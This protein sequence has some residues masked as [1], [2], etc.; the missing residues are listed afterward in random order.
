MGSFASPTNLN[1]GLD[2]SE[3]QAVRDSGS[4]LG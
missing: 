2:P 1:V 4:A 3:M